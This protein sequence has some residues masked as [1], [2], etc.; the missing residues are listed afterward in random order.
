MWC[1]AGDAAPFGGKGTI[2]DVLCGLSFELSP[3]SF[4]QVNPLQTERLYGEAARYAALTGEE[5]LFDLYCGTGTIGLSMAAGA[6]CV[7]GAEIV[8]PAVENA[9][10]NARRNGI[11][12]RNSSAEMLRRRPKHWKSAEY[13]LM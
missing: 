12:T 10:E 7:I 3:L 2:T 9:R 8:A 1:W 11:E 6:G 4:Y 5:T 13:G